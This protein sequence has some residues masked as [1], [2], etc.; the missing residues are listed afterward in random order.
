MGVTTNS[1]TS[2]SS[3]KNTSNNNNQVAKYAQS[4]SMSNDSSKAIDP[5]KNLLS[6]TTNST[7]K[8]DLALQYIIDNVLELI[9]DY[10]I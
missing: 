7:M 6:T 8:L 3:D 9:P 2:K 4:I 1:G 5:T 10:F